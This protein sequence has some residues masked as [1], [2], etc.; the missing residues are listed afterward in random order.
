MKYRQRQALLHPVPYSETGKAP[1][2]GRCEKI[3][4]I[5]TILTVSEFLPDVWVWHASM[6]FGRRP[7]DD[8]SQ[9]HTERA[10]R[11]LRGLLDGVGDQVVFAIRPE[12]H[13]LESWKDDGLK[14]WNVIND[15]DVV[16]HIHESLGT[17]LPIPPERFY[18]M[19]LWKDLTPS[20]LE[21]VRESRPG[22][23]EV[24]E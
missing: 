14:V 22:A 13:P 7:L 3:G 21:A 5:I 11:T 17:D 24:P 23:K 10:D 4:Q 9:N 18:A 1:H 12:A 16:A 20:E 6:S 2:P 8:W 15:P 19:H